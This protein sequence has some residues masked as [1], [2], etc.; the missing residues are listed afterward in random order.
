MWHCKQKFANLMMHL[1]IS[2]K[3]AHWVQ[4]N[5]AGTVSQNIVIGTA[6]TNAQKI[7]FM[8]QMPMET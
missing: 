4:M 6:K 1:Q 3:C 8:N 7:L 5:N 2:S